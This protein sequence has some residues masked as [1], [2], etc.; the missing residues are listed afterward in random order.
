[1]H[2][3]DQR[4]L[5]GTAPE[6]VLGGLSRHRVGGLG[7][8]S[9]YLVLLAVLRHAIQNSVRYLADRGAGTGR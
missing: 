4:D 1:M 8:C 7:V 2:C 3:P 6:V 5:D 9:V